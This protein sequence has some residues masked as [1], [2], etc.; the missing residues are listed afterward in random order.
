MC[1]PGSMSETGFPPCAVCEEGFYQLHYGGRTCEKCL[2]D[3]YLVT[4]QCVQYNA[5][6][7]STTS[8]TNLTDDVNTLTSFSNVFRIGGITVG[9]ICK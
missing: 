2:P 8:T 7:P 5:T 1:E 3:D 9:L 6:T 4:P